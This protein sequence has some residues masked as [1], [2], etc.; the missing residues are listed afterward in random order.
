VIACFLAG[1]ILLSSTFVAY[2]AFTQD[3]A[4]ESSAPADQVKLALS[5]MRHLTL[6]VVENHGGKEIFGIKLMTEGAKIRYVKAETWHRDR[7]DETT[8]MVNTLFNPIEP[9]MSLRIVVKIDTAG[10]AIIWNAQDK[11][12]SKIDSGVIGSAKSK[13]IGVAETL[14]PEQKIMDYVLE[15]FAKNH[16]VEPQSVR[17]LSSDFMDLYGHKVFFASVQLTSQGKSVAFYVNPTNGK[18]HAYQ[19]PGF[20]EI[21]GVDKISHELHEKIR[22]IGTEEEL[23]LIVSF[24]T[25]ELK[26]VYDRLPHDKINDLNE[27]GFEIEEMEDEEQNGKPIDKEKLKDKKKALQ[28]KEEKLS[29]EIDGIDQEVKRHNAQKIKSVLEPATR[30]LQN[31]DGVRIVT[32]YELSPSIFLT[33]KVSVIDKI[34]SLPEVDEVTL[35]STLIPTLNVSVPTIYANTV[36]Q[37]YSTTGSGVKVAVIDSGVS[38][39]S[40]VP[41][42]ASRDFTGSSVSDTAGHGTTVAGVIASRHG[43][44]KG[45]AYNACILNA[46]VCR[47]MPVGSTSCNPAVTDQPVMQA[48]E[49]AKSQGAIIMNMSLGGTLADN[50]GTLF[51]SRAIDYFAERY[52]VL[53][54]LAAGNLASLGPVLMPAGAFNAISVGATNDM[55]TSNRN[56][57][58]ASRASGD[59]FYSPTACTINCSDPNQYRSKPDLVAPGINIM[60]TVPGNNLLNV[61]GTSYAAPHV[62]GTAALL[63]SYRTSLDP[64]T[65]KAI[66]INAAAN[67]RDGVYSPDWG[68]GYLDAY[69][70]RRDVYDT[71]SASISQMV[72]FRDYYI[73]NRSVGDKIGVTLTWNR[74]MLSSSSSKTLSDLDLAIYDSTGSILDSSAS[75]DENVEVVYITAPRSGNYKVRVLNYDIPNWDGIYSTTEFENFALAS[76]FYLNTSCS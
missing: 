70:A 16:E 42:C 35:V 14:P 65:A 40:Y 22:S 60:T 6:I 64:L 41:V 59:P 51:F 74:H 29:K 54:T 25:R 68:W 20:S 46:K 5:Q 9:S 1:I 62:A 44:Y 52:G 27:L 39:N 8:V 33:A 71:R 38:G 12:G 31:I 56:D 69:K 72:A 50:R 4:K 11:N 55:N 76:N 47:D 61:Y 43:T 34:R 15:E 49:W 24:K 21:T 57:R 23:P 2:P 75:S 32:V 19:Q 67:N 13:I 26:S 73:C 48:V 53:F 28:D 63:K 7:I 36:W 10:E 58:V 37:T 18:V 66:I 30:K 45:V 3:N 17:I